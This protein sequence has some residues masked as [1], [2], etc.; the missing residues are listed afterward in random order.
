MCG[1]EMCTTKAEVLR[2]LKNNKKK[3]IKR[4]RMEYQNIIAG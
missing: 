4:L 3:V 2:N 1:F